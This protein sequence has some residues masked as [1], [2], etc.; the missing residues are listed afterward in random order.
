MFYVVEIYE[1]STNNRR[2]RYSHLMADGLTNNWNFKF[3]AEKAAKAYLARG[4]KSKYPKPVKTIRL[5]ES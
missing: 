4:G 2:M 5:K 3:R 1:C